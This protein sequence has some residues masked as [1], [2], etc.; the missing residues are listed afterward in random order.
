MACN[1]EYPSQRVRAIEKKMEKNCAV[2]YDTESEKKKWIVCGCSAS[3][4]RECQI[5]SN[6]P[7]CLS[8]AKLFTKAFLVQQ[9]QADLHKLIQRPWEEEVLWNREKLLF[10][11]TQ[12]FVDWEETTARLKQQLRFGLHPVFPPKPS[13]LLSAS[14]MFPCP[15]AECRGYVDNKGE[16]GS[17]KQKVCIKCREGLKSGDKESKDSKHKCDA[18]VLASLKLIEMESK[19]CPT[20]KVGIE[21]S[22]GCAHMFCTF[23]RTHFDWNT[24]KIINKNQSSNFHYLQSPEFNAR[25]QAPAEQQTEGC[26]TEFNFNIPIAIDDDSPIYSALVHALKHERRRVIFMKRSLYNEESIV[27]K[28]EE[29]LIKLRINYVKKIL[30]KKEYMQKVWS[31]EQHY[32]KQMALSTAWGLYLEN[33]AYLIIEWRRENYS[34]SIEFIDKFNFLQTTFQ[35]CFTDIAKDYSSTPP[36]FVLLVAGETIPLV[37]L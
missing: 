3:V 17:C 35:Q 29:S 15:L 27:R 12:Q 33:M 21:K 31:E 6:V 10:E 19:P 5:I 25:P 32:D 26:L 18:S 34:D 2:C 11:N 30:E 23:C 1:V 16:C 37:L 7:K 14:S 8:C 36:K 24:L 22:H 9:K 28:H 4:C 13:G 20:C